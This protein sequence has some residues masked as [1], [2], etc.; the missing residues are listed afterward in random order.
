LTIRFLR[1]TRI[2]CHHARLAHNAIV[3][4]L[5]A[6]IVASPVTAVNV[7]ADPIPI[8]VFSYCDAEAI[9]NAIYRWSLFMD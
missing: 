4:A 6:L 8:T 3:V 5:S 9:M 7:D 1:A 2:W